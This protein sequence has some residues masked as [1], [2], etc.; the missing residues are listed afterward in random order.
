MKILRFTWKKE[1]CH[2]HLSKNFQ[3]HSA[4]RP[5][6]LCRARPPALQGRLLF[7]VRFWGCSLPPLLWKHR[8][9]GRGACCTGC[10]WVFNLISP[11]SSA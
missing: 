7:Q 11:S 9:S 1:S 10:L 4:L 3:R 2:V 6:P 8:G 5:Q